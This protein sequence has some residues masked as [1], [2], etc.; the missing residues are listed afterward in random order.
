LIASVRPVQTVVRAVE[1]TA[2][3]LPEGET[4]AWDEGRQWVIY[5]NFIMPPPW[6]SMCYS[7][8]NHT[9]NEA[10]MCCAQIEAVLDTV[11]HF[12]KGLVKDG[13]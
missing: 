7:S 6:K 13:G 2:A 4:P 8:I 12:P 10:E 11:D 1:L 9:K 5:V 3:H